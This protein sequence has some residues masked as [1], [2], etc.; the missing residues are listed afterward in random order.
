MAVHS[1][2]PCCRPLIQI[3]WFFWAGWTE[4]IVNLV[5]RFRR[6]LPSRVVGLLEYVILVPGASVFGWMLLCVPLVPLFEWLEIGA[7]FCAFFI[8][9][10]SIIVTS[11]VVWFAVVDYRRRAKA[12]VAVYQDRIEIVF[13]SRVR[14][15]AFAEVA[16]IRLLQSG[17]VMVCELVPEK[18]RPI[19]LP[20]DFA[21]YER[22]R[23]TLNR[24]MIP[25]L[26]A[27]VD[28]RLTAG[29]QIQLRE[30]RLV[31][32]CRFLDGTANVF[33]AVL[34]LLS[35]VYRHYGFLLT[36][37]A[38]RAFKAGRRGLRGGLVVAH[39]GL[40]IR[41][42]GSCQTVPW[43][44]VMLKAFDDAGIVLRAQGGKTYS[45]SSLVKNYWPVASWIV[46]K[47]APKT[48]S[49]LSRYHL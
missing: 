28:K 33:A 18:D 2:S 27:K 47:V 39:D 20:W 13:G 21:P 43:C 36:Q 46:P 6:S 26:R 41:D 31:A 44:N 3:G 45:V 1:G 8:F 30:S 40:V 23:D 48:G 49:R 15:I 32:F 12:E 24:T 17:S 19:R 5:A 38:I 11:L 25:V 37:R 16:S 29:T 10:M 22:I 42:G 35:F 9:L 14:K 34:L 7:D 4:I